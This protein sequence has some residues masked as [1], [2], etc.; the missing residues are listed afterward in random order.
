MVCAVWVRALLLFHCV[1]V[2][3]GWDARV[4]DDGMESERRVFV[5]VVWVCWVC[6]SWCC[7]C[8]GMVFLLSLVVLLRRRALSFV[9]SG[10]WW[11][12]LTFVLAFLSLPVSFWSWRWFCVGR[13]C[14]GKGG[15]CSGMCVLCACVLFSCLLFFFVSPPMCVFNVCFIFV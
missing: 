10:G 14:G 9:V 13:C 8:F 4:P 3:W 12:E 11:C 2:V 1:R 5:V 15:W 7:V 6:V